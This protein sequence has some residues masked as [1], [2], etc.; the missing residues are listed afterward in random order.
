MI[1]N[2][3]QFLDVMRREIRPPRRICKTDFVPNMEDVIRM[4]WRTTGVYQETFTVEDLDGQRSERRKWKFC[5]KDGDVDAVL[6]MVAIS[7]F[8]VVC[9]ED[10][11]M[12]QLE[13]AYELFKEFTKEY[14]PVATILIL[15]KFDLTSPEHQKVPMNNLWSHN[16]DTCKTLA[17]THNDI[18]ESVTHSLVTAPWTHGLA[19]K[20]KCSHRD[21]CQIYM[22]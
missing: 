17:V 5:F 3:S 8:N 19:S 13:E 14:P 12:T 15:N 20:S 18:T 4:R 16:T 22:R 1:W 7:G 21:R 6:F 10:P 9:K 2:E 11:S